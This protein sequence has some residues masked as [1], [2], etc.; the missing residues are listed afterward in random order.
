MKLQSLQFRFFALGLGL[1][2]VGAG[3]RILY[4]LPFAQEQL[5]ELV[6]SQQLSL[7]SY[8]ARDIDSSVSARR[9]LVADVA[10]AVPTELLEQPAA[11]AGWLA[12]RQ[13]LLPQLDR[14][15][16]VIRADGN[17]VLANYPPLPVQSAHALADTPWFKAALTASG[18]VIGKPE[19]SPS[20]GNPVLTM[21]A[22]V[23]GKDNRV[24][25][26]LAAGISLS[27]PGFLDRLQENRF[28][29]TG[30]FLLISPA[31]RLFVGASD[32]AMV[33]KPTPSPGQNTLHDRAMG[34][35]RGTDITVNVKGVEEFASIVSVPSA[36]WYVVARMPTSEA[37]QPVHVLR[38][39]QIKSSVVMIAFLIVAL[40]VSLPRILRPLTTTA[41]AMREMAD[42][43]RELAPLT[44]AR[45]DEV[46]DL[47][48]G[49]NYLVT[50]LREKEAALVASEAH[51]AYIA[52]HD[53][54]TGLYNR[55]VL[56]DRLRQAI[57]RSERGG[58]HFALLFC[59]LD[60]FK[61]INDAHGHEVGDAVLI[62]VATR[63]SHGRR[64]VDTVARH[65]GDEFV[66]LLSD[67]DDARTA[68]E[69]V[70]RQYLAALASP[71]QVAEHSFTLSA[72]I[73]I[74]LHRGEGISATQM[75]SQA[76]AAMYQAKR[77]GKNTLCVFGDATP[78]VGLRDVSKNAQHS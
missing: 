39:F 48:L 21:A 12:E 62:E 20:N 22:P 71:I 77:S 10:A 3:V 47:V 29:E 75:M 30:G 67:L 46:G 52:H 5:T 25:A 72:S 11:L 60:Y 31:D 49:F 16:S 8:I 53:A 13:R 56:E 42:G 58:H 51:M 45:A 19:A 55:T 24:L 26:V 61:P 27:R 74:A 6:S 7:A 9:A 66:I 78:V 50:R 17:A 76:D 4:A 43:K 15:L 38:N 69:A 34:G 64:R 35:F 37:L 73:G 59:D 2:I 14:G 57:A 63:L 33:L 32:P 70:A 68:A 54:L 23:L 41:R 18:A 36:N 40:M 1:L 65:G 44:I 28:G